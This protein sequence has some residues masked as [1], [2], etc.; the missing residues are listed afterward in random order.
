MPISKLLQQKTK[1]EIQTYKKPDNFKLLRNTHIAFTGS[2]QKHPTDSDKIIII[3]DPYC[4][5]TFYYEFNTDSISYVEEQPS[6]ADINGDIITMA[7]I[8]VKKDTVGIRCTPFI[9]N[10]IKR[11]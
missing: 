4:H 1:F 2:P 7:R 6:I 11:L 3:V 10:E 8:W 5:N 9:V